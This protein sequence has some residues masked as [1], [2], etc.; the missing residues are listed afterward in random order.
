MTLKDLFIEHPYYASSSN[1]YSN[2]ASLSFQTMSDFI[3]EFA[4]ADIDMNLIYRWDVHKHDKSET[5]WAEI[6]IIHQR[7]GIYTPI[8][9]HHFAEDDVS[10]FISLVTK[11]KERLLECWKPIA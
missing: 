1:Y 2:E 8:V 5:Y 11:H 7:Q 6:F 9:I 10:S 3:S 4:D